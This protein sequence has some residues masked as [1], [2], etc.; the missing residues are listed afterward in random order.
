M[1]YFIITVSVILAVFFIWSGM[2]CR[3]QKKASQK[4]KDKPSFRSEQDLDEYGK[5]MQD[6]DYN[7]VDFGDT[8]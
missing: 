3:K 6:K 2:E 7:P 1:W 4:N 5:S 8:E